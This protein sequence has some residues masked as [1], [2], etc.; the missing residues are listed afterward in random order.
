MHIR[1]YVIYSNLTWGR[2]CVTNSYYLY[3]SRSNVSLGVS[4]SSFYIDILWQT[5]NNW[6]ISNSIQLEGDAVFDQRRIVVEG[7]VYS[8][9]QSLF[10]QIVIYYS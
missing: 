1:Q 2:S 6:I 9:T 5:E 8:H 7:A 4:A 10:S 3:F